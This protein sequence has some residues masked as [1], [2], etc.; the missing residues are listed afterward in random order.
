MDIFNPL[1]TL[2]MFAIIIRGYYELD[3]S[4]KKVEVL[5]QFILNQFNE[6]VGEDEVNLF[7][8]EVAL[9][10]SD[11][12]TRI[13]EMREELG[14]VSEA[15]LDMLSPTSVA[16]VLDDK[17]YNLSRDEILLLEEQMQRGYTEY[18]E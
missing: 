17:V 2:L 8:S 1:V 14:Q 15:Y 3:K 5:T 9:R 7:A 16:D 10:E 13:N 4:N 18:S 6:E 11:F 12:D